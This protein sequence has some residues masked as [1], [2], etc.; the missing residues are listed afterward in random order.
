MEGAAGDWA[1]STCTHCTAI[2]MELA[3][4]FGKLTLMLASEASPYLCRMEHA[5]ASSACR[6]VC[7]ST[8]DPCMCM[9]SLWDA[10]HREM[11]RQGVGDAKARMRWA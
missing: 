4:F 10:P 9:L 11:Q 3:L 7:L 2:E 8:H 1:G 5:R 6:P